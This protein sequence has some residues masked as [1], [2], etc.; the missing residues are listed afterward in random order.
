MTT[1]PNPNPPHSLVN[2]GVDVDAVDPLTG[3]TAL[4]EACKHGHPHILRLLLRDSKAL[5][6]QDKDGRTPLH[7]VSATCWRERSES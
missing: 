6:V 2:Y 3:R 5:N 1:P 7:W 4:H